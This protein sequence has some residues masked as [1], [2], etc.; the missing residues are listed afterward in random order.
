MTEILRRLLLFAVLPCRMGVQHHP[1][2]DEL[3]TLSAFEPLRVAS[4]TDMTAA[5]KFSLEKL[6]VSVHHSLAEGVL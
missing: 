1:A 3:V 5:V 6:A 2:L 4:H